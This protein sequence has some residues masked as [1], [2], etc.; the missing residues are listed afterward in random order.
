MDELKVV[1]DL[2]KKKKR[3]DFK[4]NWSDSWAAADHITSFFL[5]ANFVRAI[6]EKIVSYNAMGNC[7]NMV[8]P[9]L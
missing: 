1:E 8:T 4:K 3:K 6:L 2:K 9:S 7:E 5:K